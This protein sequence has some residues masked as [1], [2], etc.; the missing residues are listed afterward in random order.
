M[1]KRP[2]AIGTLL[3]ELVDHL[4]AM[5]AYWDADQVCRFANQAY[6]QWFG[7]GRQELLGVTLKELLGP[8]YEKNLPFIEA[9]YRGEKQVFERAIPRPDGHGSRHS[10]ATYIPRLVDGRVVGIFVHVADVEPLKRLELELKAAKDRAEDMATHDFLTG[11]PNR[12]LLEAKID[13]AIAHARRAGQKLYL[14]T[15]DLDNFKAIND[16]HGHAAGDRFLVEVSSRL[17]TCVREYDTLSRVGGDEFVL[18][19]AD[20]QSAEEVDALAT[21]LLESAARPYAIG[22]VVAKPGLSIGVA[23][24]PEHGA[25]REALMQ[26]SDRALYEAKGAGR[27]CFRLA[28]ATALDAP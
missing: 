21:R 23:W 1:S 26:A 20:V 27:N 28:P 15:I 4:D 25:D 24:F 9:A 11:L 14:L 6:Q 17:K 2:E 12:V 13:D 8:L 22:D 7:R 18:L 19:T 10:L 5:V 16:S 3:I